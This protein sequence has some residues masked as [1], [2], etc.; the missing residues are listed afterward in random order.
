MYRLPLWVSTLSGLESVE[1]LNSGFMASSIEPVEGAD[2]KRG[3]LEGSQTNIEYRG[4][5][6]FSQ[7]SNNIISATFEEL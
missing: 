4:P 7:V 2:Q 1:L 3:R 5:G 6:G